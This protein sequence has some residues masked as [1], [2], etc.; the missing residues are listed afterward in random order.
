MSSSDLDERVARVQ[1]TLHRRNSLTEI[2]RKTI[3]FCAERRGF[4]DVE[5]AMD[6]FPEFR[7]ADQSQASIIGILV[8]AGAIEQFELDAQG[9][10][11]PVERLRA[12]TEDERDDAVCAFALQSTRAGLHAIEGMEP[13]T[14]LAKLFDEHPERHDAYRKILQLCKTPRTFEEVS[15]SLDP[16][17]TFASEN[18]LSTLPV[19]PSALLGKLEAAGG[20]VWDEAWV[21][22]EA[23]AACL[24]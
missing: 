11:I 3:E 20:I 8:N 18:D 6:A 7:Y 21:T 12:M 13:E 19:Y 10:V 9:K 4:S 24:R 23:G 1:K 2:M 17:P 15:K 14:K 22:T 16:N 5:T